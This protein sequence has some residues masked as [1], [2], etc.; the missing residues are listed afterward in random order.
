MNK[1]HTQCPKRSNLPADNNNTTKYTGLSNTLYRININQKRYLQHISYR[2]SFKSAI[3]FRQTTSVYRSHKIQTNTQTLSL[4]LPAA[5]ELSRSFKQSPR[6]S[7]WSIFV[8]TQRQRRINFSAGLA[9]RSLIVWTTPALTELYY[10]SDTIT[11]RI[12]L[13]LRLWLS[14]TCLTTKTAL[15]VPP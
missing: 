10:H 7:S 13:Q 3:K 1:Y 4:P 2:N 11:Q 6:L 5:T 12:N 15:A 14:F 9:P 8:P